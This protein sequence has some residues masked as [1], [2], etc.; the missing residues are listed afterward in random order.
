MTTEAA[1]PIHEHSAPG[2]LW[3]TV[4]TAP[5]GSRT[6]TGSGST[7]RPAGFEILERF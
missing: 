4:N 6:V 2:V 3:T 7:A 1:N 5:A